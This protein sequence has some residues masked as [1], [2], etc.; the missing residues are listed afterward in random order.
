MLRKLGM[1]IMR[2][3]H[4]KLLSLIQTAYVEKLITRFAMHNSKPITLSLAS[5]FKLIKE[6]CPID[7]SYIKQRERVPYANAV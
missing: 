2:K 1:E 5:H 4:N 7:K 6:Q 3:R